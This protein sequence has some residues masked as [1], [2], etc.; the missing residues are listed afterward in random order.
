MA[1]EPALDADDAPL[2]WKERLTLV[3]R[4]A[5]LLAAVVFVILAV[6][7]GQRPLKDGT[8]APPARFSAYDGKVWGLDRFEGRPLVVNFWGSWCPPCLQEMPHLVDA[9]R[10][11]GEQVVFI[12][13]AV[14]SPPEEVFQ[15][16]ERFGVP[17][18]V[19]AVDARTVQ[20]WNARGLPSTYF[21]N[22]R[23]EVVWSVFGALTASELDQVLKE[24][25]GLSP[26]EGGAEASSR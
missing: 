19:A 3:L 17:Y 18:P 11:Y 7:H 10:R 12:G 21:L 8:P 23:H 22:E 15:V 4:G 26:K 1:Q 20:A 13:A 5:L 14:N 9:A 24:R 2:T 16:I 6:A 25:L